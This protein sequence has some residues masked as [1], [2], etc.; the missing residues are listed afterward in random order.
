MARLT[1]IAWL[2]LFA[3][4]FLVP[5]RV[6]ACSCTPWDGF[7]TVPRAGATVPANLPA[8][9]VWMAPEWWGPSDVFILEQIDGAEPVLLPI[10]VSMDVEDSW[11]IR[12]QRVVDILIVPDEALVADGNYRVSVRTAT[13]GD[14]AVMT[15]STGPSAPLPATLGT[16]LQ[17]GMEERPAPYDDPN[18]GNSCGDWRQTPFASLELTLDAAAQPWAEAMGWET[19]SDGEDQR[20]SGYCEV[21]DIA[22]RVDHVRVDCAPPGERSV[23]FRGTIP[24]HTPI[25][26]EA[27]SVP[28]VGE[29]E[30]VEGPGGSSAGCTAVNT[31]TPWSLTLV[32]LGGTV[33]LLWRRRRLRA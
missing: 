6:E 33:A 13:R 12:G 21:H 4:A 16:A 7:R 14:F 11:W 27:L 32:L 2:P 5:A 28:C 18:S 24:G 20:I 1:R 31:D 17:V 8:I 26:S 23:V 9:L 22:E 10:E 15:F 3:L 30:P 19:L 29:P 25:A